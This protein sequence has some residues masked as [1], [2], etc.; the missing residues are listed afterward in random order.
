MAWN[1]FWKFFFSCERA[2]LESTMCGVCLSVLIRVE[3]PYY[4]AIFCQC[5][6]SVCPL[7]IPYHVYCSVSVIFLSVPC[8][9]LNIQATNQTSSLF[10]ANIFINNDK[11]PINIGVKWKLLISSFYLGK[12]SIKKVRIFP[13]A[14]P[15]WSESSRN[16]KKIHCTCVTC[17]Q[18]CLEV[19]EL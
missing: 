14:F 16:A 10:S 9:F 13:T 3:I 7:Y 6:I 2:A 8:T 18:M 11:N 19:G 15:T 17:P 1:A 12:G 5:D 4:F